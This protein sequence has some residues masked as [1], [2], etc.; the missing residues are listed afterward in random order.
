MHR[1]RQRVIVAPGFE[2]HGR[3]IVRD[4]CVGAFEDARIERGQ[5]VWNL[6]RRGRRHAGRATGG[7]LAAYLTDTNLVEQKAFGPCWRRRSD[8]DG[9]QRH[10]CHQSEARDGEAICYNRSVIYSPHGIA[11]LVVLQ[12]VGPSFSS[13]GT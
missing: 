1:R 10:S 9:H 6:E 3:A 4:A 2:A 13:V 11:T 7:R 5:G 12:R 8:R